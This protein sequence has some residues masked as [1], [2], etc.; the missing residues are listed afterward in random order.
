MGLNALAALKAKQQ[1]KANADTPNGASES[2]P[3][4]TTP[5][6]PESAAPAEAADAVHDDSAAPQ[7][8]PSASEAGAGDSGRPKLRFG[9]KPAATGSGDAASNGK[10]PAKATSSLASRFAG[11]TKP[12]SVSALPD[13]GVSDGPD[14]DGADNSIG[15]LADLAESK[16]GAPALSKVRLPSKF[17]D[18]VPADAPLREVEGLADEEKG[19]CKLLDG[20]YAAIHEPDLLGNVVSSLMEELQNH[21]EYRRLVQPKDIR[22]MIQGM[23]SAMGMARIKKQEK[24]RKGTGG[25]RAKSAKADDVDVMASLE[26]L[27]LSNLGD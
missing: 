18:E 12:S 17:A 5:S 16:A 26:E 22:T 9:N 24:S 8:V 3:V 20:V 23:R 21:P 14:S 1:E 11:G 13:A 7:R 27:G 10:P 25:N 4:D 2:A 6:A 19:F 15:S